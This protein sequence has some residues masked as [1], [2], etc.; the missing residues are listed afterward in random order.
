MTWNWER[1]NWPKFIWDEEALMDFSYQFVAN[2]SHIASHLRFIE[3]EEEVQLIVDLISDEA[4]RSSKIEG[5]DLDRNSL[6]SSVRRH[7][8][9]QWGIKNKAPKEYG[10]AEMMV[11]LYKT[12]DQALSHDQ[13]FA[14]HQML[15]NGRRD[16]TTIGAYRVHQEKMQIVSNHMDRPVVYF[17][18]PPSAV[19]SQEMDRFIDWFNGFAAN[20]KSPLHA[21]IHS[22]V[23]HLYFESIHPFEDGNGRIGRAITEKALSQYLKKPTLIALSYQIEQDRKAYYGA[24]QKNSLDLEITDWLIYFCKTVIAAQQHTYQLIHFI[25]EKSRFF[26]SYNSQL[27]DRQQKVLKRMFKEGPNGFEG[28]LSAGNYLSIT[29]TSRATATRDLQH[30]VSIGALH[31]QGQGRHTRYFLNIKNVK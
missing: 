25:T 20:N 16:L 26:H 2:A 24:L 13:L 22:G 27:N 23:A 30:L 31:K 9:L 8:G 21:L 4:Y 29:K 3:K 1:R 18:A 19:V 11:N 14:W 6:Q 10:I 15:M 17:E 12:Y 28:G 5:E 7:F